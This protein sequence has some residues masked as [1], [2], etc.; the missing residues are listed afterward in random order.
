MAVKSK[1]TEEYQN[2]ILYWIVSYA[3]GCRA[4]FPYD[5]Y[6]YQD[7][8]AFIGMKMMKGEVYYE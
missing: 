4:R 6:G 3:D 2:G 7:A 8:V 5:K 1:P